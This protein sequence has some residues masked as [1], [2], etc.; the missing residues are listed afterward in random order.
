M[1]RN[2]RFRLTVASFIAFLA[3]SAAAAF[4]AK[5]PAARPLDVGLAADRLDRLGAVIEQYVDAGRVPG[6]VVLVVRD[7]KAAYLK[8]FGKLDLGRGTPMPVD[9]IF[10]IASQSKAVTSVAIMT[11]VEE[12]RIN[13]GDPVSKFIPE[14][15][16]TKVAVQAADKGAA[17]Y[18][19]VPARREIT[20]RDLLTH[21]AGISYGDGPA[22][23]LYK[24]A[25]V[26]GWSFVAK[27]MPIGDCIRKLAGLPFDAQ[28]GERWVYGFNTDILGYVVEVV[29]EMSL[30][31]Y[32]AKR[33]TG[34]LGMTDTHFFLPEAEVG[35]FAS[36]YGAGKDGKLE[37]VE[38][39]MASPYVKGPRRCFSGGAGL[40][41]TAEDY[42]RFLQMLA[43]GGAIDGVRVLG[44]KT[45][46]VMTANQVGDLYGT[47][48]QGFGLGFSET[49]DLGKT[50]E[51][52]SV[53]A[54][55]WGGAYY[56]TYWVDPAERLVAVFMTQLLPAGGLDL[57]AKFKT[58]VYQSII[59][60]HE[61]R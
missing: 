34:P 51:M 19:V 42:G 43:N 41:S 24:A 53:G 45:V 46:E 1:S 59:D 56:T 14:F 4:A 48:G 10:R 54:F 60:S 23:D 13:L 18:S 21:T 55:G 12:G 9:G 29:S 30:A 33:I 57:Q 37:L 26:Q 11:L 38:D 28:P 32:I 3:L 50:G 15:K 8:A 16:E 17:G 47:R 61:R 5:F 22:A 52:G 39:A 6:V 7:G 58:L 20:I 36:V 35:R 31:D 40:L 44:P 49:N 27:D 25:G 2:L